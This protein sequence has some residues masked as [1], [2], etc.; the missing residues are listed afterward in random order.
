MSHRFPRRARLYAALVLA[1][2]IGV[3]S[4]RSVAQPADNFA[5]ESAR[6]AE[7]LELKPGMTVAEI[8]AGAGEFTVAIAKRLGPS[9]QVFSTELDKYRLQD[10]KR[11]SDAAGL[12]N[13]KVIEAGEAATNLPAAC[14]DAIFMRRVYH[15]FTHPAEIDASLFASLKPGGLLAVVDFEPRGGGVPPGVPANRGGHGVHA[16]TVVEEVTAAGFTHLRTIRDWPD[17]MYL[18]LFRKP[19]LD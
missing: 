18:E 13:V 9:S 16:Q 1:S 12:Q 6:L 15:H 4:G 17:G 11:A 3:V 19:A 5:A 8:G 10:I 7:A 14:C 2:L